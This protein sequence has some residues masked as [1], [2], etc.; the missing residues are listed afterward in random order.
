MKL[1]PLESLVNNN[2]MYKVSLHVDSLVREED[3]G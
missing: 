1:L 3:S 2:A